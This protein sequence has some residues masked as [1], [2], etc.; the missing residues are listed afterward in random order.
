MKKTSNL[1]VLQLPL[2][3]LSVGLVALHRPLQLGNR[4][5][6]VR[7][8]LAES[9]ELLL[10]PLLK[11]FLGIPG[12]QGQLGLGELGLVGEAGGNLHALAV[13]VDHLGERVA[14]VPGGALGG[15]LRS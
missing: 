12:R 14:V 4:Q 11:R 8:S 7:D 9:R 5:R 15:G 13:R 6:Q 10:T 3:Q 2:Q 1:L